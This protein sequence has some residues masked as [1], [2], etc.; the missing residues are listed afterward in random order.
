MKT[1]YRRFLS[2]LFFLI[3]IVTVLILSNISPCRAGIQGSFHTFHLQTPYKL[4]S[5]FS[6]PALGLLEKYI[7][8][9]SVSPFQTK[10]N[11]SSEHNTITYGS[12]TFHQNDP[13]ILPISIGFI[14]LS[15]IV[16][17]LLIAN[18]HRRRAE[19]SLKLARDRYENM[20]NNTA[21]ALFEEDC[22]AVK[23]EVEKL[24]NQGVTDMEGYLNSNPQHVDEM[25]KML[26]I[27]DVNP[28]ALHLY[29]A[30]SKDDLFES[31]GRIFTRDALDGFKQIVKA[32]AE[33]Q[34]L[35]ECETVSQKLTGQ[36]IHVLLNATLPVKQEQFA[37]I[38]ISVLDITERKRSIEVMHRS[39]ER[40]RT[41][42]NNAAS[43]MALV[44]LRGH[45]IRVNEAFQRMLGY[46]AKELEWK[47]WREVTY[48]EDIGLTKRMIISLIAGQHVQPLEKRYI[49]KE[50]KAVWAL[51]NI[52]LIVNKH[53]KPLYYITQV[54]DISKLKEEQK[55]MLAREERYR[56]I[57]EADLSGFFIAEPDGNL[58]LCNKIFADILGFTYVEE[59]NGMNMS[60]FFK[61]P[62]LYTTLIDTLVKNKKIE[63]V[64]AEFVHRDGTVIHIRL[65]ATGHFTE[66]GQLIEILGYAMDITHQKNLEDQLLQVRKLDSA[67]H[68]R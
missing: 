62:G 18:F 10:T 27:L 52:A 48:P 40:F 9:D 44:D 11:S 58:L 19:K 31:L 3:G 5:T 23:I 12:F 22:Q 55:Q 16:I 24:K 25:V 2:G 13:M 28:A 17:L 15:V 36:R 37:S 7:S 43:G 21:V 68:G 60:R 50:G 4:K 41:V 38:I 1:L 64:E 33:G 6:L 34:T 63:H 46:T 57:F 26:K 42:F 20:F 29:G 54:Q 66:Q 51:L 59:T 45:Y 14:S 61:D 32:I 53:R 35:F 49:T 65:N 30:D 8:S 56:Q 67:N 39:E 47:N